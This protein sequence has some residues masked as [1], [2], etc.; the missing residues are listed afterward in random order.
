MQ[1][2]IKRLT[3]RIKK[4]GFIPF[5]KRLPVLHRYESTQ[6]GRCVGCGI[7]ADICPALAISVEASVQKDGLTNV[8]E[9]LFDTGRCVDCGLCVE[10]CPVSAIDFIPLQ[11]DSVVYGQVLNQEELLELGKRKS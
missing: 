8:E 6:E 11:A 9:F 2:L 1:A 10:A 7:C 4:K 3:K 5:V